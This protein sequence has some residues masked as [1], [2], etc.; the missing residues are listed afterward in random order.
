MAASR[1]ASINEKNAVLIVNIG[2]CCIKVYLYK[3]WTLSKAHAPYNKAIV[4]DQG[5]HAA[6]TAA[7]ERTNTK[8]G[9]S[10]D[11]HQPTGVFEA[12]A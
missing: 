1:P 9:G 6:A 2:L 8:A 3:K 7:A 5:T 11:G 10:T 12:G 4:H